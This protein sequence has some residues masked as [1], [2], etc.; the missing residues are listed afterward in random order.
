MP[1]QPTI[2]TDPNSL[3]QGAKCYSC[4]P[5]GMKLDV[6]IYLFAEALESGQ[7]INQLLEG[8][9][10]YQCI[11]RGMQMPVLIYMLAQLQSEANVEG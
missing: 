5:D 2:L 1:E 10:C 3:M 9:K 6:L 8:A 11:P 4:I 7:T